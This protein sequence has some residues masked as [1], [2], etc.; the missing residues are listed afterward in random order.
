MIACRGQMAS[1]KCL[2]VVTHIHD[3][4]ARILKNT[5]FLEEMLMGR[6]FS[7]VHVVERTHTHAAIQEDSK[8]GN[9]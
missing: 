7:F 5:C 4:T 8:E 9:T 2:N 6:A 3:A 1:I